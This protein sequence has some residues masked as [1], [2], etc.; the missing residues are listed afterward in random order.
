[1]SDSDEEQSVH[2][3]A[4]RESLDSQGKSAFDT[5][6][7]VKLHKKYKKPVRQIHSNI[8]S[9]INAV[10]VTKEY[11]PFQIMSVRETELRMRSVCVMGGS[12]HSLVFFDCEMGTILRVIDDE[13]T[14]HT[15]L[16]MSISAPLTQQKL[17]PLLCSGHHDGRMIL[18]DMQTGLV[19]IHALSDIKHNGPVTACHVCEGER[20]TLALAAS[21]D[22]TGRFVLYCYDFQRGDYACDPKY[23][24]TVSITSIASV[25]VQMA[26]SYY[27]TGSIDGAIH[28]YEMNGTMERKFSF[29]DNGGAVFAIDILPGNVLAKR[30]TLLV[31]GGVDGAVRIYNLNN[32]LPFES[33]ESAT[34]NWGGGGGGRRS[35]GGGGVQLDADGVMT[36]TDYDGV[37]LCGHEGKINAIAGICTVTLGCV[38][39]GEDGYV[40]VWNLEAATLLVRV[41]HPQHWGPGGMELPLHRDQVTS[42]SV[43]MKPR[44][45]I[46]CGSMDQMATIIDLSSSTVDSHQA[47]VRA[48]NSKMRVGRRGN[49]KPSSGGGVPVSESY[50][51]EVDIATKAKASYRLPSF[52]APHIKGHLTRGSG[53]EVNA[54]NNTNQHK[55]LLAAAVANRAPSSGD[56]GGYSLVS[57]TPANAKLGQDTRRQ[58]QTVF[59]KPYTTNDP[60]GRSR[61]STAMFN[62][63]V[64]HLQR[65]DRNARRRRLGEQEESGAEDD[66]EDDEEDY[67]DLGAML[68][69]SEMLA[70]S[71]NKEA[72]K[73]PAAGGG[74]GATGSRLDREGRFTQVKM[75]DLM[76][77]VSASMNLGGE[78]PYESPDESTDNDS[79]DN[80]DDDGGSKTEESEDSE[81][82]ERKYQE[83][84]ARKER[85][86]KERRDLR[87]EELRKHKER[88]AGEPTYRIRGK[89]EYKSNMPAYYALA[90]KDDG[91]ALA[92]RAEK[93]ASRDTIRG[94]LPMSAAKRK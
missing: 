45:L 60:M 52:V 91:R 18:R 44:L 81:E 64:D 34:Q 71:K 22:T 23:D 9:F 94:S 53:N 90:E 21:Q 55:A 67:G 4:T 65:L 17:A 79:E 5:A 37:L 50:T 16:S 2:T 59:N 58:R 26:H 54:I 39:G 93:I 40:C 48:L 20:R 8:C 57:G 70:R 31:S 12:G 73:K 29:L 30:P 32:G 33:M 86:R 63:Q 36:N 89:G 69:P 66:E 76:A 74:G 15:C 72:N 62:S 92:A 77:S 56:D 27:A 80:I 13:S 87:Q 46:T 35:G 6:I 68:S 25:S 28:V 7:R 43:S 1:M 11:C 3:V 61:R 19:V 41:R 38:T 10:C 84:I 49:N 88:K 47:A 42:V 83:S 75:S 78:V 82:E 85:R 14:H 24:H 51:K